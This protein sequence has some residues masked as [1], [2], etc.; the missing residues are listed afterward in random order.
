LKDAERVEGII[1]IPEPF[2]TRVTLL[3]RLALARL[4]P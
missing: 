3:Y 2:H 1:E 4:C